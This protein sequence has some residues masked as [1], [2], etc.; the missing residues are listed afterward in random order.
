MKLEVK[1]G[2]EHQL[3]RVKHVTE[4]TLARLLLGIESL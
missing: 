3:F 4:V 2:A 1:P